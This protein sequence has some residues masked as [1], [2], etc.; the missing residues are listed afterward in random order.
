MNSGTTIARALADDPHRGKRREAG[1]GPAEARP[2]AARAPRGRPVPAA[3]RPDVGTRGPRMP[4]RWMRILEPAHAHT[5]RGRH[6]AARD[7]LPRA[8]ACQARH[9]RL[10]PLERMVGYLPQ[11]RQAK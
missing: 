9:P 2:Y 3:A 6:P 5:T 4:P 1:R 10:G 11:V 8:G 7:A